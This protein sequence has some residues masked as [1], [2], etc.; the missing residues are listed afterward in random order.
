M[1]LRDRRISRLRALLVGGVYL[2]D[3][4]LDINKPEALIYEPYNGAHRLVGV[5]YIVMVDAWQAHHKEPPVLAG[6][7]LQHN[8]S[9]NRY[10]LPAFYDLHVWAWR[11][12]PLG[13]FAD[14]NPRVACGE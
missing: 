13:T 9:P 6:Q 2:G 10:G 7:T 12:N 5:E 11:D 8:S 4:E 14:W 1:C 3:D